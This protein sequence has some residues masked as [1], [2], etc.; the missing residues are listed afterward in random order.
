[1]GL[2]I[3]ATITISDTIRMIA[4]FDIFNHP[5][6]KEELLICF[7]EDGRATIEELY[8]LHSH[9]N[10]YIFNDYISSQNNIEMLVNQR[11]QKLNTAM[12]YWQKAQPY[13]KIIKKS[14][15]VR[16]VCVSGSLS[17]NNMDENSDVD[18]FIIADENKVYTCK[19][20]LILFKK[21]FLLNSRKYFCVNYII[22]AAHLEIP[23]KNR[24]TATEIA[25]LIPLNNE[26]LFQKFMAHNDWYKTYYPKKNYNQLHLKDILHKPLL[27][28]I[29]E[30]I[31]SGAIG[32]RFESFCR[33]QFLKRAKKKQNITRPEESA[34][35]IRTEKYTA[36]YHPMGYQWVVQAKFD[37]IMQTINQKNNLNIPTQFSHPL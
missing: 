1:M 12:H 21:I 22:D 2:V 27:T 23:D 5:L 8:N 31:L 26:K 29:L 28:W 3:N 7:G 33:Q 24:F 36:K 11:K 18:Y 10:L 32:N 35:N 30:K 19:F 16:T 37:T 17:K 6:H 13:F 34:V 4:Y 20:F 14:P 25:Y 15:F 9:Y